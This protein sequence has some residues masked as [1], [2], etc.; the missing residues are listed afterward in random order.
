MPCMWRWLQ[1]AGAVGE[2]LQH[3]FA[4]TENNIGAC[5]EKRLISDTSW[6]KQ[7]FIFSFNYVVQVQH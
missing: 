7:L 6:F 1:C 2:V 4:V 5:M 3:S